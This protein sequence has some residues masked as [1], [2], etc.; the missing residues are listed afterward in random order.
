MIEIRGRLVSLVALDDVLTWSIPSQ[1]QTSGGGDSRDHLQ[2]KI[3]VVVAQNDETT[4]GL[5]V[6]HLIGMQEV[7][8]K[9]IERNFRTVP[10]LAGASILGDGQVS[11]ILD[12]DAVISMVGQATLPQPA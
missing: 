9:P 10:T 2:G 5:L 11:L 12:I 3:T 7:V 1:S 4:L 8:L 6:D